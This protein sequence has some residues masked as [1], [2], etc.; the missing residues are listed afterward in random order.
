MAGVFV[1]PG[2]GPAL[3]DF[4]FPA[5]RSQYRAR[6]ILVGAAFL[7]AALVDDQRYAKADG[8][9]ARARPWSANAE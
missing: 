9:S 4:S 1:Y 3:G 8:G 7:L 2:A 5:R 6:S